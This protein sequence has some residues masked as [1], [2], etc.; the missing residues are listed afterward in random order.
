MS[1]SVPV[2][3]DL[4]ALTQRKD[5][6]KLYEAFGRLGKDPKVCDVEFAAHAQREIVLPS[7]ARHCPSPINHHP[8]K[9]R[10]Q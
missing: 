3:E 2:A 1:L 9:E 8:S 4:R 5:Y 6:R 10:T 7:S